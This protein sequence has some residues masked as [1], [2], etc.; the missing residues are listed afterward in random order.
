M[1]MKRFVIVA[2]LSATAFATPPVIGGAA[3]AASSYPA[4]CVVLPLLKTE[5]REPLAK[6]AMAVPKAVVAAADTTAERVSRSRW[7]APLW[8]NCKA[9]PAGSGHLYDCD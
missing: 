7:P 3:Q 1:F 8:W 9:A 6:A 5:C 4:H 2:I